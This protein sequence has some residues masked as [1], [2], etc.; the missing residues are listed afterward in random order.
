MIQNSQ[1]RNWRRIVVVVAS[2]TIAASSVALSS[3]CTTVNRG[4]TDH[5]FVDTVPQGAR[6]ILRTSDP[7]DIRGE[8]AA[9]PCAIPLARNSELI[10]EI[11]HSEHAPVD[12]LVTSQG[13]RAAMIASFTG[14]S[15]A[16]NAAIIGGAAWATS[17]AVEVATLGFGS[18]SGAVGS[19]AAGAV[20]PAA[21]VGAVM[22]MT[23][24][25][26]GSTKNL[27]PNPII[28]EL[29]EN[30]AA[31]VRDPRIDL[32]E[33]KENLKRARDRACAGLKL[34]TREEG[35]VA[36]LAEYRHARTNLQQATE[37]MFSPKSDE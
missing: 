12:V 24:L 36:A 23:D 25:A 28:V 17:F 14:N 37:D 22:M 20:G 7:D 21:G 1:Y 34:Q 4:V 31:P 8:C 33:I 26:T 32:F 27:A 18:S 19:A 5:L 2:G 11:R 13:R 15:L 35:C 16:S 10:A 9:T 30:N 6:V 3:G 29:P